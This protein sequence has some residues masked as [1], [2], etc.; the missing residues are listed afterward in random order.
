MAR[1][2]AMNFTFTFTLYISK[3]LSHLYSDLSRGHFQFNY[4]NKN[5]SG[6]SDLSHAWY[7]SPSSHPPWYDYRDFGEEYKS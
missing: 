1:S 6:I 4:S 7:V 5:S 3:E 2:R